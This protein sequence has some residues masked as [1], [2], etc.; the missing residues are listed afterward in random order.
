MT[1]QYGD[2]N[3]LFAQKN[4]PS[5]D[6]SILFGRGE[7]AID[8]GS[9]ADSSTLLGDDVLDTMVTLAATLDCVVVL[10]DVRHLGGIQ[11]ETGRCRVRRR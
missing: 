5:F 2:D 1:C 6:V 4:L 11:V 7:V 3:Q 8:I 10:L 9:L